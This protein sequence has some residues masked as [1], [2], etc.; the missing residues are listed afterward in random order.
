MVA[1]LY[2][3]VVPSYAA[4]LLDTGNLALLGAIAA[5][6]LAASCAAQLIASR[7]DGAAGVQPLGLA[8][9][10][11]GL[12]ALVLA[13]PLH[14]LVALFASAL[15]GGAG[16]GLAFLGAQ[17]EIN[18]LAPVERRGEV[19]AAFISWF[20]ASVCRTWT[21]CSCASVASPASS[22]VR[23]S[24]RLA[25]S[26][27]ASSRPSVSKTARRAS[28]RRESAGAASAAVASIAPARALSSGSTSAAAD[29]SRAIAPGFVSRR[30]S[31]RLCR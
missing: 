11:A 28:S 7:R 2:L 25:T 22:S 14:S 13:F 21:R 1:A 17:A 8:L 20:A 27:A 16:H 15:L 5:S 3:S 12:A 18:E 6:L 10:G 23:A 29:T 19:T 26:P 31:I 24:T 30:S 4:K 9:V